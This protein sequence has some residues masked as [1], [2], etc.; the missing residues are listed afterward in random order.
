ML[1]AAA[2]FIQAYRTYKG[3]KSA[4]N[5]VFAKFVV[6][7]EVL[8]KMQE[9]DIP[10][11]LSK[12]TALN[13]DNGVDPLDLLILGYFDPSKEDPSKDK[14]YGLIYSAKDQLRD[15]DGDKTGGEIEDFTGTFE[16]V[17]N[18]NT[19]YQKFDESRKENVKQVF[20]KFVHDKKPGVSL[21]LSNGPDLDNIYI[22]LYFDSVKNKGFGLIY[23]DL[24][25]I[26]DS[27]RDGKAGT[28]ED[29]RRTMAFFEAVVNFNAAYQAAA[30]DADK[31]E[32][33][34]QIL[35]MFKHPELSNPLNLG[36]GDLSL[37]DIRTLG[38][39]D[40]KKEEGFGLIYDDLGDIRDSDSDGKAGTV[41]D[42]R[43]TMAF[44]EAVANFNAA[45]QAAAQDADKKEK[46]DQILAMFKHPELSN[47]LNLGD[48]DLSL[49]DIRTL[50]YFDG[51]KEEGFGLIYDDL[52]DIRDSDSDGK[53]GTVEDCTGT[54]EAFWAAANFDAAY[55]DYKGDK[56]KVDQI[57]EKFVHD[58]EDGVSLNLSNG[59][60][61]DDIYI[62]L[63]YDNAQSK[64]YGLI[65]EGPNTL[66]DNNRNGQGG[67]EA[68]FAGTMLF[69]GAVALLSE[70][71][72]G[73]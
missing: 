10:V 54:M 17:A 34:D 52:G 33:I 8:K 50:G 22:L 19:A 32:K 2:N 49:E 58:K 45:Y 46:I 28:V 31:K 48:G 29:F 21:D 36:D 35:A 5:E 56:D 40:G 47:P 61:L 18:F 70:H 66:R 30:Q 51:K 14:G 65:Y 20:A 1:N 67:E 27:D 71:V 41:E 43:R 12:G 13:I 57:F 26:R 4:V 72:I 68:D 53:A 73:K 39:F 7:Q 69:F 25:D 15:T 3:N 59:L 6:P 24:G 44:F 23:D 42:F 38:Y 60:D 11:D 37:E 63:Y 16:A 9:Q 55:R 64:G 62:L